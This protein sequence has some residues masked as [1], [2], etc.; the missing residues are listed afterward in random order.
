[1]KRESN[2]INDG[3]FIKEITNLS[4]FEKLKTVWDNLAYKQG[5]FMPFLCFDWFKIW[6]EHFLRDNKLF[7]LLLYKE[8]EISNRSTLFN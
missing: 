6:L 4:D 1:M 3:Y 2:L 7:I 5:A 8:P